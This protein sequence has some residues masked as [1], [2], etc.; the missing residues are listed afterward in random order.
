MEQKNWTQKIVAEKRS[1][2]WLVT[3]S[4]R[5]K[6]VSANRRKVTFLAMAHSKY[7]QERDI[8]GT[9][10]MPRSSLTFQRKDPLVRKTAG[11]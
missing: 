11:R 2:G 8:H 4:L 5:Q 9:R 7:E 1:H 3:P 10:Q 6:R